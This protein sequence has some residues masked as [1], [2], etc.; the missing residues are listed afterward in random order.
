MD[1][2]A[3][4]S[5][6]YDWYEERS[7]IL[8]MINYQEAYSKLH[9]VYQI[10]RTELKHGDEELSDHIEKLLERIQEVTYCEEF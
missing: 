1:N 8:K 10:C 3:T 6:E 9:E 4:F 2:K 7:E 5:V